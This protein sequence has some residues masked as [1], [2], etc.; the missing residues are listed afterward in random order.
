MVLHDFILFYEV[1]RCSCAPVL[2]LLE[3]VIILKD[4]LTSPLHDPIQ[5][6]QLNETE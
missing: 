3:T 5:Y 4:A 1:K 2:K 6:R